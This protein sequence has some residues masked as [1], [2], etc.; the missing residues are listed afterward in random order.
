MAQTQFMLQPDVFR[1]QQNANV[2]GAP[3]A[4]GGAYSSARPWFQGGRF[5]ARGGRGDEWRG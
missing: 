2:D 4:G 5:A 1:Q 3:D